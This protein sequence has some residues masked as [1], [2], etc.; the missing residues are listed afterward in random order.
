[1]ANYRANRLSPLGE[2]SVTEQS[3]H[4]RMMGHLANATTALD[5]HRRVT[6]ETV[7]TYLDN[8]PPMTET[9]EVNP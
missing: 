5:N 6:D 3:N 8:H 7:R 9:T 4:E 1:M 2:Y